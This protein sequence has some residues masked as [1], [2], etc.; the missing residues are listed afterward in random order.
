MSPVEVSS[1][2]MTMMTRHDNSH[3]PLAHRFAGMS[4]A[5]SPPSRRRTRAS[6]RADAARDVSTSPSARRGG[7]RG[8]DDAKGAPDRPWERD[9]DSA[10]PR[11]EES[12]PDHLGSVARRRMAAAMLMQSSSSEEEEEEEEEQEEDGNL[13]VPTSASLPREDDDDSHDRRRPHHP[14]AAPAPASPERERELGGAS[15]LDAR[16]TGGSGSRR[17]TPP[18][19]DYAT[20]SSPPHHHNG[21]R[22]RWRGAA[23]RARLDPTASYRP[24]DFPSSFPADR[25]MKGAATTSTPPTRSA[26]ARLAAFAG[27]GISLGGWSA[28]ERAQYSSAASAPLLTTLPPLR[29]V[30][31][32]GGPRGRQLW[33]KVR[34]NRRLLIGEGAGTGAST[35]WRAKAGVGAFFFALGRDADG[36]RV[37]EAERLRRDARRLRRRTRFPRTPEFD[38]ELAELT[39]TP[40]EVRSLCAQRGMRTRDATNGGPISIATLKT[41]LLHAQHG[42]SGADWFEPSPFGRNKRGYWMPLVLALVQCVAVSC[43]TIGVTYA[44]YGVGEHYHRRFNCDRIWNWMNPQC[45]VADFV[46]T[47]AKQWVYKWYYQVGSV[48]AVRAGAWADALSKEAGKIAVEATEGLA[49]KMD[50]GDGGMSGLEIADEEE[51]VRRR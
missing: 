46:R 48:V 9:D 49:K 18:E 4:G 27:A 24:D 2:M 39:L 12:P 44:A 17:A 50:V 37:S 34:D 36:R 41:R 31:P 25:A 28:S 10:S 43:I 20:T 23:A 15:P 5:R 26:F 45:Q 47:N 8:N 22:A 32:L 6:G 7:G 21:V 33:A 14:S 35:Y 1:R 11:E 16:G 38:A 30:L 51:D 19:R 29:P 42:R 13:V 40:G 3:T